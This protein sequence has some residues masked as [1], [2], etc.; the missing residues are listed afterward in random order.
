MDVPTQILLESSQHSIFDLDLELEFVHF[1]GKGL[2][3]LFRLEPDYQ[4]I[5]EK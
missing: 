2:E 5:F 1:F 4:V 3:L